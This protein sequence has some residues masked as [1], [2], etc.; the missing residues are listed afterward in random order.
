[1]A[2]LICSKCHRP[3]EVDATAASWCKECTRT[4]HRERYRESRR[5]LGLTVRSYVRTEDAAAPADLTG[6]DE[7]FMKNIK[8]MR[9]QAKRLSID[10]GVRAFLATEEARDAQCPV[11]RRTHAEMY[12]VPR[13]EVQPNENFNE[14]VTDAQG[15]VALD[16]QEYVVVP[17]RHPNE[18][19]GPLYGGYAC[20]NCRAALLEMA[21]FELPYVRAAF[22]MKSI[23][24]EAPQDLRPLRR[25]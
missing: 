23:I 22:L 21:K 7:Q 11:C 12:G 10:A 4:Y 25:M 14:P 2:G 9:D 15:F 17:V 18:V 1:M 13:L 8:N 20:R 24:G 16:T 3:R 6:S 5:Q 19:G